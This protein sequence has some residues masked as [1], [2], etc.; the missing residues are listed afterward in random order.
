MD[1]AKKFEIHYHLADQSHSMDASVKNK[2]E[3]EFLAVANEIAD[4]L[5]VDLVWESQALREGGIR[6]VWTAIGSN[7]SQ[8][9]LIISV[10]ALVWSMVPQ[11]DQELVDLQKEE[12]RLSIEAKKLEIKRLKK[13][14]EDSPPTEKTIKRASRL[15]NDNRKVVIRRSN[16]YKTLSQCEKVYKVGFSTLGRNNLQIYDELTIEHNDFNKFIV[17]SSELKPTKVASARI[18][19]VSPVLKEGKAKWKGIYKGE[20]I[21]FD[22]NDKTFKNSVLSRQISFKNGSE[23][24]CILLI[25]RSIDELGETIING[26]SVD[27]VLESIESGLSQETKQ[28]KAYR[29][30]KNLSD[31]QGDL[32]N[33]I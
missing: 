24:L 3:A 29:H 19:I 8:I 22:M 28:G 20:H 14:L 7:N 33:K 2:C 18:E 31:K 17:T 1:L 12:A 5:G 27:I 15:V 13:E 25:H 23:I 11:N 6:E 26:Y 21:N 32:F 4:I 30:A 10:L 9:A 16:F